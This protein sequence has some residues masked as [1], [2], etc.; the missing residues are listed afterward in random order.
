MNEIRS[1][2]IAR[3]LARIRENAS[4]EVAGKTDDKLAERERRRYAKEGASDDDPQIPSRKAKELG[5]GDYE[6]YLSKRKEYIPKLYSFMRRWVV[7]LFI[8]LIVS[9][10]D[11]PFGNIDAVDAWWLWYPGSLLNW[12]FS[13]ELSDAVIMA[14]VG[15]TTA[16]VIGLFYVVAR[17]LYPSD[18]PPDLRHFQD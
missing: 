9:A 1:E 6:D 8:V 16:N 13:F 15:G 7:W 11:P 14:L 4:K 12:L 2:A 17:Y 10:F 18:K 3:A 5:L